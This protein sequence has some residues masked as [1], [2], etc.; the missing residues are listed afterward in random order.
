MHRSVFFHIV[1]D[2][3]FAP[4][5][6]LSRL[7]PGHNYLRGLLLSANL[8]RQDN[9]ESRRLLFARRFMVPDLPDRGLR[10]FFIIFDDP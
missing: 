5:L 7:F 3:D 10:L 6:V 2:P 4:H 9:I 8:I 1:A